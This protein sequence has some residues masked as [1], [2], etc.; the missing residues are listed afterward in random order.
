MRRLIER[1]G[2]RQSYDEFRILTL[3][4]A[5]SR[6]GAAVHLDNVFDDGETKSQAATGAVGTNVALAKSLEQVGQKVGRDALTGVADGDLDVGV[7]A[8]ESNLDTAAV[9]RELA[10]IVGQVSEHLLQPRR[11]AGDHA[12]AWVEPGF[13]TQ[14]L[15]ADRR[16]Q[17]LEGRFDGRG[18]VEQLDIETQLP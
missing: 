10:R 16:S 18:E 17:N 9:R 6:D 2:D 3:S 4:G 8:L 12:N 14:F 13:E 1:G 11:I 5:G 7:D 15:G